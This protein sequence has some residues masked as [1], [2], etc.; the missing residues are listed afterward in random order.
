MNGEQEAVKSRFE[1]VYNSSE[2]SLVF[3]ASIRHVLQELSVSNPDCNMKD[4]IRDA[5]LKKSDP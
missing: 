2:N 5:N 3:D 1:G 4:K